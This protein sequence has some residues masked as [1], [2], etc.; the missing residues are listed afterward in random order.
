[1]WNIIESIMRDDLAVWVTKVVAIDIYRKDKYGSLMTIIMT[2]IPMITF[3][4][5]FDLAIMKMKLHAKYKC[6]MMWH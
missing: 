1:M 3:I 2:I 5:K 6:T 4:V